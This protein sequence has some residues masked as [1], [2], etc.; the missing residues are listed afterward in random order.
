MIRFGE[1]KDAGARALERARDELLSLYV[2]AKVPKHQY[3]REIANDRM[4]VLQIVVQAESLGGQVLAHH[5]H[6]EVAAV[7]TTEFSR[8]A[9]AQV[10]CTIGATLG[11]GQQRLPFVTRQT[12]LIP[13]GP[14]PLAAMIKE[15]LVIVDCLQRNDLG[16]N[17][18]VKLSEITHE[19]GWQ[20]EVHQQVLL[21]ES[22]FEYAQNTGAGECIDACLIHSAFAQN[23]AAVS[24][25]CARG[26]GRSRPTHAESRRR[27]G[28]QLTTDLHECTA[29]AMMRMI[30]RLGECQHGCEAGIGSE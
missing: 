26:L 21:I 13:I 9:E 30:H 4:L 11:L 23:R 28:L 12:T 15:T 27:R 5:R 29:C 3:G 14:R 17:E 25:T 8:Q 1:T 7:A 10:S 22:A 2:G 24:A 19:I 6:R 20:V 16:S 18:I